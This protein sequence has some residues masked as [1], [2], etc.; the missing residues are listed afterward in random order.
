MAT[1]VLMPKVS[2][3]VTE[4]TIIEWLKKPGDRVE[5]GEPLLVIES[6]K[7]T[8]VVEAPG[9]GVL[10][11]ELAPVGITVPVTTTIG[12]ILEPGE[13]APKLELETA[14][15]ATPAKAAELPASAASQELPAESKDVVKASPAAKRL[16][17]E[18]GIDLAQVTGT[19]PG[20]RIVEQDVLA[21]ADAQTRE[22]PPVRATGVARKLGSELGVDL[23]TVAGTGPGGRVTADDVTQASVL[24]AGA[25]ASVPS[26]R[27]DLT[28]IQRI[29]AER[30]A[31]S[32]GSAPH[33]YLSVHVDMSQTV[34]LREALLPVL[35]AQDGVRLSFSDILLC[36]VAR[37][38]RAHPALNAT[39]AAG[40]VERFQEINIALAV[41]TPRGL[42]V[43]VFRR[44][45]RLPLAEIA[46]RREDL[47]TR[48]RGNRLTPDDLNGATF[49]VSNLGMFGIDVFQAIINPPQ[50]AILAVGR[51]SKQ[52]LVV[53]DALQL[54]SA[55]W[56]TLSVDHRVA[57]G[58]SG[59]RFLQDLVHW[60]EMPQQLLV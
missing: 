4:G 51:I 9:T 7:A 19:G 57:D 18:H 43:P 14:A 48:A 31:Q 55:A 12:Y 38:L 16:A 33:F 2:F 3:I 8:V 32:F 35:E 39:F 36:A 41:D 49:T 26:E 30:M 56:L 17:R 25:V 60:L 44:V 40:H 29:A 28:P 50:A 15:R 46:R 37:A 45:D 47:V 11:P 5:K 1:R 34:A 22:Q 24:R 52:P 59:A 10:S 23:S 20:G 21:Y 27:V 6:E 58:A 54:R 13:T 53:N 42:T